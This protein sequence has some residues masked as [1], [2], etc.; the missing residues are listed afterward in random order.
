MSSR[1]LVLATLSIVSTL[2]CAAEL[3]PFAGSGSAPA[4]PW[5]VIGLPRQSKPFTRFSVVELDGVQALRVEADASYGNLIHPLNLAAPPQHLVWRWRVDEPIA[6]ADLRTREGDDTAVK[7]C[8]LWDMPIEQV[9]FFE[10]QM[11]RIARARS[12][13]PLPAATVCYVW[14]TQLPAGTELPSPFTG[15]LRYVVLR[16]A[17]DPLHHWE[18][19]RRDIA[20]DFMKLFG[21]EAKALPPLVGV[22]IGADADNTRSHSLAHM[23]QPQLEP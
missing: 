10:R 5:R 12:D 11:L 13:D 8:T 16:G 23:T 9:P 2:A 22:A 20:A 15:R 1:H 3:Q 4:A 18:A 7:V 19:E 21:H 14:D 17:G 6:D